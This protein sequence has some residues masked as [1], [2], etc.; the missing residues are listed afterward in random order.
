MKGKDR[1]DR[2]RV[3]PIL[4]VIGALALIALPGLGG[5]LVE[6]LYLAG[7]VVLATYLWNALSGRAK[8][9]VRILVHVA[10]GFTAAA[11]LD[12]LSGPAFLGFAALAFWLVYRSPS[13][14]APRTG[15]ALIP[16]GAIAT[17]AMVSVVSELAPRWDEGVVF[18]LGMT[19]TFT[20]IYLLPRDRGG[21]RWALWPALAW[22]FITV[23]ANDPS[24][25]WARWM[26]PLVLI[27]TGIAVLGWTRR[28]KG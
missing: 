18:L 2:R 1:I 22:A 25:Q 26:L 15:W 9:R 10:L 5:L 4:I 12:R 24:G 7:F 16:A 6:L 3:G 13:K 14:G 20:A 8:Q 28:K 11:T 23:L 17:L 19:A 27:G 21:G